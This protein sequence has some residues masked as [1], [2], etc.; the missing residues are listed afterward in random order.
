MALNTYLLLELVAAAILFLISH[1]LIRYLVS[2]WTSRPLPPGPKG[3]PI[4]GALPLLAKGM[5]HV[6]LANLAKKYGPIMHLKLGT[7]DMVVASNPDAARAFLKTLDLNFSNRPPN[8]GATHLAY[9]R[10]DM[11]FADYGPRWKL[12]RKL[13]NIHMLGGKALDDWSD[14]RV[15]EMNHV[16]RSMCLA[17]ERGESV[18]LPEIL[19]FLI[20]NMISQVMLGRR[21]FERRGLE[22]N[23][24]KEM[25][26]ELMTTAGY[27][28]IG[29]FIPSINWMDLQG[30]IKGMKKLHK[31]FDSL[32]TKILDEHEKL[33]D[34]RKG[35]PDFLDHIKA[36]K[37]QYDGE[38]VTTTNIKAL[39]L[40]SS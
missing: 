30:I 3:L 32:L 40:V 26:V 15:A 6:I 28:N 13:S 5:P 25:V 22:S 29:D 4:V 36:S 21:L 20:A 8:A 9:N 11:V 2:R 24:F 12:L 34:D 33:V 14:V 17:S 18:L 23:E 39:L 19:N 35:K 1:A 16:I 37:D 7:S 27:F 31:R 10:E 38:E